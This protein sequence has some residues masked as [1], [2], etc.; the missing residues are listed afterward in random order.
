MTD[1]RDDDLDEAFANL[2]LA[3]ALPTARLL[4]GVLADALAAQPRANGVAKPRPVKRFWAGL[5]APLGGFPAVAAL[6]SAAVLGV[7]VGYADPTAAAFLITG[8][9]DDG[10]ASVDLL[11]PID[12]FST[13]G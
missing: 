6:C 11:S 9:T 1:L 2:R 12:L 3:A 4:D 10:A 7:A 8:S 5:F 13:E